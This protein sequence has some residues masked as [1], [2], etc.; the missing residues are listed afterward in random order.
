MKVCYDPAAEAIFFDSI[1]EAPDDL[2]AFFDRLERH[3]R[4]RSDTSV[5]YT[6]SYNRTGEMRI[7]AFWKNA[8]GE[9]RDRVTATLHWQPRKKTIKVRCLLTP[10]ELGELGFDTAKTP[11]DPTETLKSEVFFNEDDWARRP[12]DVIAAMDAA[13]NKAML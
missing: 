8:H 11:S 1:S 2:K 13:A 3:F 9:D 12:S 10:A 7:V 4:V 5:G 6:F